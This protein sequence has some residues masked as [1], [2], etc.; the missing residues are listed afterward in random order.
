MWLFTHVG[1][2]GLAPVGLTEV[3]SLPTPAALSPSPLGFPLTCHPPSFPAP[4]GDGYVQAD[5]RGPQDY[6]EHLYVNTQGLDAMESEDM[7]ETPLLP[8]DSPKKDLFDMRAWLVPCLTW[9]CM[10]AVLGNPEG[11]G[12]QTTNLSQL[13]TDFCTTPKPVC[14]V[15][16]KSEGRAPTSCQRGPSVPTSLARRSL[17]LSLNSGSHVGVGELVQLSPQKPQRDDSA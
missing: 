12:A 9:D 11:R 17:C 7:F 1:S 14:R 15:R 10:G 2:L 6:E 3:A 4:P 16:L 8:E 13:G 5:A